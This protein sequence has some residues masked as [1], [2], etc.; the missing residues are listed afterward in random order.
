MVDAE[1]R[2]H[3]INALISVNLNTFWSISVILLAFGVWDYYVDPAH[4]RVAFIVR[5]AGALIVIATGLFQKLPG[6]ARWMPLMAKV[7][8]AVAVVTA[9]IAASMLDTGF[10]FGVAGLV[11]IFLTGPYV[12]IDSRDLLQTNVL[13]MAVLVPAVLALGLPAFDMVGTAVFVLLAVAVSTLLG[14]VLETS[15]RRAFALEQELHHDARTDSLTGLANRRAMEERGRVELKLAKRSGAP[16]SVI[17]ADL[18]HFKAINDRHGHKAGDAAL[19]IVA[20]V[21]RA[22]L[23]ESDA[24]GRWGGEEFIAVLPATGA[25]GAREVAERMR[26]AIE[27]TTFDGP[28]QRATISAG[29][30]T[31]KQIDDPA[32]EWDLL[33]KEADRRLYRAKHDGRNRVVFDADP[34]ARG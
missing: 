32:L 15:N 34:A 2:E 12:A 23:R 21:L 1:F 9:V 30:T 5:I 29:V 8:L 16:V 6:K 24:L 22:A 7:R 33:I 31:S 14:R 27:A 17:L 18:D 20:S 4:W 3:R 26:S 28:Q 10:G 19:V 13:L 25:A 11:A